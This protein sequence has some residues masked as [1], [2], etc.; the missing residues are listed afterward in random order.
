MGPELDAGLANDR[1]EASSFDLH[2]GIH[3]EKETNIVAA[4]VKMTWQGARNVGQPARLGE[5][6]GLGRDEENVHGGRR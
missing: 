2:A 5:G 6:R 3:R 1:F 4:P